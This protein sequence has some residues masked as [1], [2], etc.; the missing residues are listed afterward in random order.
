MV[1][2]TAV[3]STVTVAARPRD[4]RV[5]RITNRTGYSNTSARKMPMKTM[6]NVSPIARNAAMTPIVA[7]SRMIVRIGSRSSTRRVPSPFMG[8]TLGRGPV[9]PCAG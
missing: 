3:P 6:R 9:E 1:T 8:E 5:R 2:A 7:A 4:M